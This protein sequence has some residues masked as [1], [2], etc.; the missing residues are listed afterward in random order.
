MTVCGLGPPLAPCMRLLL[1]V[2]VRTR[3][4]NSGYG[5]IGINSPYSIN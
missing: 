1:F 3:S 2:F 5:S 4:L